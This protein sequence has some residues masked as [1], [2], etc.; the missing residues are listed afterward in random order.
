MAGEYYHGGARRRGRVERAFN[1][2]CAVAKA[3]G[4]AFVGGG[5]TVGASPVGFGVNPDPKRISIPTHSHE[6][7]T[8]TTQGVR[9]SRIPGKEEF[10]REERLDEAI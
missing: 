6:R 8:L 2:V 3:S 1:E 10:V 5:T 9:N 4:D 7:W